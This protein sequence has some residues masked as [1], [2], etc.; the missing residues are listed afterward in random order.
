MRARNATCRR[1]VLRLGAC[2]AMGLLAGHAATAQEA[3]GTTATVAAAADLKFALD[4]ITADFQ[5][6]TPHRL[7]LVF[8][9][10]GNLSTQILQG[11]PF[12][13]FLSADEDFVF[14]LADA[15]RTVDRGQVYALGHLGIFV[16]RGSPLRPDPSLRDLA[17]ALTDGRL[18]RF[19][20]ANPAHAPY[21]MRA[22]EALQAAGLWEA[23][24]PRLVLG[25]NI[26]QAA[27][28]V[29]S[30]AAQAGLI[31][32]SLALAPGVAETGTFAQVPATTHRPLRQRMVLVK[33]APP[34]AVAL[35]DHLL[36]APAQAVLRRFGF[37]I[38][39][40]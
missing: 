35:R 17:E 26:S 6:R 1:S 5:Q 3:A 10:S 27:Q 2:G 33:G 31:S 22:R 32:L 24:Q 13:L 15:G 4:R 37:E 39:K 14:R 36:T 19:A 11:A 29:A 9:A 21:G 28:F 30:G 38:P 23:I 8:G 40:E 12:H 20:I 18:E 16:P 34:A 7:R 25:E